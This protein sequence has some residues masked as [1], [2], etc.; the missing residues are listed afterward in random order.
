[1]C[2]NNHLQHVFEKRKIKRAKEYQWK[3]DFHVIIAIGKT[4]VDAAAQRLKSARAR[5]RDFIGLR[6]ARLLFRRI[7]LANILGNCKCFAIA[8]FTPLR[9]KQCHFS[10]G[11][12]MEISYASAASFHE[13]GKNRALFFS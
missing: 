11:S 7:F 10:P 8:R 9:T 12:N 2:T 3:S 5:L 4:A 6:H 13:R 1:M